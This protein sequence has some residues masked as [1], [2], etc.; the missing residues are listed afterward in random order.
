MKTTTVLVSVQQIKAALA[1]EVGASNP[2]KITNKNGDVM[3]RFIRGFADNQNNILLLSEK[4][5]TTGLKI[6]EVNEIFAVEYFDEIKQDFSKKL[7]AR[8]VKKILKG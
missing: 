6:L 8:G 2:L 7:Q 5:E 3:V 4:F 1:Q